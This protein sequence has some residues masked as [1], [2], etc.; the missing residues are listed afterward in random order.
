MLIKTE[1]WSL[2]ITLNRR[3]VVNNVI[4]ST[5]PISL[6]SLAFR[7]KR[8]SVL[9]LV[10]HKLPLIRCFVLAVRVFE[11]TF[12]LVININS[13]IYKHS[14]FKKILFYLTINFQDF[15]CMYFFIKLSALLGYTIVKNLSLI[16]ETWR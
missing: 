2:L 13:S 1:T 3:S 8:L 9:L 4:Y 7:P 5:L 12:K 14:I 15:I 16:L 6:K 11:K 10:F